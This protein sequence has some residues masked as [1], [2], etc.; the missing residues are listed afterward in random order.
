ME[1]NLNDQGKQR[2]GSRFKNL[3][4]E[5]HSGSFAV[6]S[7]FHWRNSNQKLSWY[8]S[9]WIL[10]G[11]SNVIWS[12]SKIKWIT[13]NCASRFCPHYWLI[14]SFSKLDQSFLIFKE[15]LLVSLGFAVTANVTKQ[16]KETFWGFS[17]AASDDCFNCNNK[18]LYIVLQL[19]DRTQNAI[20]GQYMNDWRLE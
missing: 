10:L 16:N 17:E 3:I 11:M 7:V 6:S 8:I 13:K 19:V 2:L 9:F 1:Y 14:F 15:I 12:I 4:W 18:Q 20:R 5:W